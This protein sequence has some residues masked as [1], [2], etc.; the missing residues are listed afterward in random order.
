MTESL[1][2]AK[3]FWGCGAVQ[4]IL[5]IMILTYKRFK[6][7]LNFQCLFIT[8]FSP[9]FWIPCTPQNV[10]NV[11]GWFFWTWGLLVRMAFVFLC[12]CFFYSCFMSIL[13][14]SYMP[15]GNNLDKVKQ[16]W[17]EGVFRRQWNHKEPAYFWSTW[18]VPL[19]I[20]YRTACTEIS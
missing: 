1:L 4:N 3:G 5:C 16:H 2:R 9:F 7:G 10:C 19:P 6:D 15:H 20:N 17:S 13:L 11:G 14:K 12:C 8:T 18:K